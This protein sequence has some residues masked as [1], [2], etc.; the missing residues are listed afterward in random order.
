MTI[1]SNVLAILNI[2]RGWGNLPAQITALGQKIDASEVL[3]LNALG[4][5]EEEL[6]DFKVAVEMR[7]DGIEAEL[8]S[9]KIAIGIPETG[10]FNPTG[11]PDMSV[12]QMF[13]GD[14]PHSSKMSFSEPGAPADGAVAGDNDPVATMSL[15]PTD[16]ASWTIT[17]GS[18]AGTVNFNY[19]G[20]SDPPDAGP[21][22]VEP[23]VL[24]VVP[25]PAAETGQ[26]NP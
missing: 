15:D 4:G 19:T 17:L 2:L 26:F 9:I 18:G 16:H 1:G 24:T 10:S 25:K 23:L 21:V 22:V 8:A 5:I 20:T 7:L 12:L 11:D 3:T 6:R 13:E 14:P